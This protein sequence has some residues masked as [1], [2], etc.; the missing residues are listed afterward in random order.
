MTQGWRISR[1]VSIPDILAICSAFVAAIISYTTLDK[2]IT[3]VEDWR[4]MQH[5]RDVAQDAAMRAA[6]LEIKAAIEELRR[7]LKER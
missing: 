7:D 5:E 3:I 4:Q 1:E 2:R 6:I